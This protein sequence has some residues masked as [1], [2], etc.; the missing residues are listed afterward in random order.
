MLFDDST[1]NSINV[2]KTQMNTL[3]VD[4][5]L[6]MYPGAGLNHEYQFSMNLPEAQVTFEKLVEFVRKQG[7]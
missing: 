4:V 1:I 5:Q 7:A 2:L 3:G 6:V